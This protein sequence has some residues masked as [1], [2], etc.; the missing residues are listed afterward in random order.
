MR[1]EVKLL[2]QWLDDIQGDEILLVDE[3]KLTD[4]GRRVILA[5]M[6]AKLQYAEALSN[7]LQSGDFIRRLG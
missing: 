4:L 2:E 1:K 6:M 3:S 7:V 5:R